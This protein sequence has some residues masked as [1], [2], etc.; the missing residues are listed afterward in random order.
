MAWKS[1]SNQQGHPVFYRCK[2]PVCHDIWA[3][4]QTADS[5]TN[6]LV[7]ACQHVICCDASVWGC[8]DVRSTVQ[9]QRDRAD[10]R[11]SCPSQVNWSLVCSY[12]SLQTT[13]ACG[14]CSDSTGGKA[15][16][17]GTIRSPAKSQ[18]SCHARLQ[19]LFLSRVR[20][21]SGRSGCSGPVCLE[22]YE[23][24]NIKIFHFFKSLSFVYKV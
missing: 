6:S 1:N 13:R 14:W 5:F 20:G 8:K 3:R 10:A 15:K 18:P 23:M 21:W 24:I 4:V 11:T 22:T 16:P 9:L 17:C 19:R 2:R 12:S 7:Q